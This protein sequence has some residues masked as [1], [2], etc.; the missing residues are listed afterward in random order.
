MQ[1][2]G[3]RP[4]T[5]RIRVLIAT[6]DRELIERLE[7]YIDNHPGTSKVGLATSPRECL[8]LIKMR[9]PD[10]LLISDSMQR[11]QVIDVCREAPRLYARIALVILTRPE[12]YQDF[13]YLHQVIDTGTIPHLLKTQ[14]PYLDLRSQLVIDMITR[15]HDRIQDLI[16]GTGSGSGYVVSFF[17]LKGGVG[18]TTLA[19]N[20]AWR[21]SQQAERCQVALADFNWYFGG[22][23]EYARHNRHRSVLKLLDVL[24]N[25]AIRRSDLQMVTVSINSTLSLL[26]APPAEERNDYINELFLSD[27]LQDKRVQLVDE[28]LDDL[29]SY[30][31]VRLSGEQANYMRLLLEK[32]KGRQLLATLTRRTL[33][34]LRDYHDYAILDTSTQCDDTTTAALDAS[35]LIILVCTPDIPSIRATR[36][37]LAFLEQREIGR[38]RIAYVLN[39]TRRSSDIG[40][41]DVQELF[42]GYTMLAEIPAGFDELQ[43]CLNISTFVVDSGQ[44]KPVAQ[45]LTKLSHQ[46]VE[47]LNIL[48]HA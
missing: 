47:R 37:A 9:K 3:T 40:T 23:D 22:L 26:L 7:P 35:D 16:G 14:P 48:Q 27:V 46:V 39:R 10:V 31:E 11:E 20:L 28:L 41:L 38:E 19:A 8:E 43:P 24:D 17:S 5:T 29:H 25:I 13:E 1:T 42:S 34:S 6:D 18:K 12:N 36:A 30:G 45:A 2:N 32:L 21:L 44:R 15:A 33:Q 4:D